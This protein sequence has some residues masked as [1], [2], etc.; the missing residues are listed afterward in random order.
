MAKIMLKEA[1][2]AGSLP[3]TRLAGVEVIFDPE[4]GM[5]SVNGNEEIRNQRVIDKA[6][7][8]PAVFDVERAE[9]IDPVNPDIK[10]VRKF[11]R[12]DKVRVTAAYEGPE[13]A[14]IKLTQEG[15]ESTRLAGMPVV[16][17]E[18][19]YA[20][21]PDGSEVFSDHEVIAKALR[22]GPAWFLV[23]AVEVS[24]P[25][26]PSLVESSPSAAPVGE[27]ASGVGLMP[28]GAKRGRG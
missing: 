14:R 22:M 9:D 11:T 17:N 13:R 6:L 24:P 12:P 20:V 15:M 7:A 2:K 3:S 26:E 28:R 18:D 1:G 23:E 19:G 8:F 21:G 25:A 4:T 27:V 10:V 16:F 5:G